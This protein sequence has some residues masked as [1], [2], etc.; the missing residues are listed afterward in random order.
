MGLSAGAGVQVAR[1]LKRALTEAR[2]DNITGEAAKAAYYFFLSFFPLLLAA[3]AFAGFLGDSAFDTLMRWIRGA[4]PAEAASILQN[5]VA[6]ITK[7]RKPGALTF[8]VVMT[9]WSASNFFAAIADGLD[10]MFDVAPG[11]WW[12]KRIKAIAMMFSAGILLGVGGTLIVAGPAIFAKLGLG[13]VMTLLRWPVVLAIIVGVFFL[14]YFILPDRSQHAVKRELAAGAFAGAL[15]W[16]LATAG[17][18]IYVARMGNYGA[19]YG[20][21]GGVIVMLLWLYLSALAILF[22]GEVADVLADRR[23]PPRNGD[24]M[25]DTRTPAQ[26]VDAAQMRADRAL[27]P[28]GRA[29]PLHKGR[30]T[31]A[32]VLERAG[33]EDGAEYVRSLDLDAFDETLQTRVR[34]VESGVRARPMISVAAAVFAGFVL[35][36]ILRD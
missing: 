6:E 31:I 5:V 23:A 12:K 21:L 2:R 16:I 8:G 32:D 24:D 7:D 33:R 11:S 19:A 20:S 36:R 3:F 4:V 18:R 25:D 28:A 15:L 34:Q 22:G 30:R 1:T 9:L 14:L 35:G 29:G 27:P 13:I 26:P 17:F 10:A